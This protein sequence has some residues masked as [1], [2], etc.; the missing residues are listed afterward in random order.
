MTLVLKSFLFLISLFVVIACRDH[1]FNAI[2]TMPCVKE[3]ADW[4]INWIGNKNAAFGMFQPHLLHN[5]LVFC[6]RNDDWVVKVKDLK[7][8]LICFR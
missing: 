8:R 2:E 4:A 7:L 3:K 1:L 6:P 5:L